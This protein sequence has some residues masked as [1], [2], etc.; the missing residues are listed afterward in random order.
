M[1]THSALEI[2]VHIKGVAKRE[3]VKMLGIQ[4]KTNSICFCFI[5]V[6]IFLKDDS[7]EPCSL[8]STVC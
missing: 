1:V 8:I 2:R 3:I 5:T 6:F 7:N 4:F